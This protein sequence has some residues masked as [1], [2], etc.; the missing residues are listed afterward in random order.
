MVKAKTGR[1]ERRSQEQRRG[2]WQVQEGELGESADGKDSGSKN[3][4]AQSM[5]KAAAYVVIFRG[6]YTAK[7]TRRRR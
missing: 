3:T 1:R 2:G 6:D 5:R 7:K 4:A